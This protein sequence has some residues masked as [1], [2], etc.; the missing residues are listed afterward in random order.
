[1]RLL[2]ILRCDLCVRATLCGLRAKPASRKLHPEA[3]HRVA[4]R[5]CALT[6]EHR[7][8]QRVAERNVGASA[9]PSK[10]RVEE[11]EAAETK[12]SKE[13]TDR[14]IA[15]RNAEAFEEAVEPPP[16]LVRAY[17]GAYR[18]RPRYR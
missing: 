7:G 16:S 15:E 14:E 12:V 11:P 5:C 17:V 3:Q 18:R 8:S 13:K 10:A 1:M 4:Q 6:E 9:N 2:A